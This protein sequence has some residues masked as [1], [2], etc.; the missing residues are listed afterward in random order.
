MDRIRFSN[1][2]N[3]RLICFSIVLPSL[4]IMVI[5][6]DE[7][8]DSLDSFIKLGSGTV[9]GVEVC[10]KGSTNHGLAYVCNGLVTQIVPFVELQWL[11]L[12][13]FGSTS[14]AQKSEA[15]RIPCSPIDCVSTRT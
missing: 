3:W 13:S 6:A 2:P 9:A 4:H 12:N 7:A 5:T 11:I 14:S 8:E 15:F 1:L 10:D